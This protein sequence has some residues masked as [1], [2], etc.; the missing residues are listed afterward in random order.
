M[1]NYTVDIPFAPSSAMTVHTSLLASW[2]ENP[3]DK[4]PSRMHTLPSPVIANATALRYE[5]ER[6]L[7]HRTQKDKLQLLVKWLGY[8]HEH[9]S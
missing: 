5:V 1:D 4:F 2:L 6:L 7:K 9:N 8:G 3:D